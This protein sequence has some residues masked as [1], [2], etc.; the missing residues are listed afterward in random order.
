[1]VTRRG[2]RSGPWVA[3]GIGL[4]APAGA[5][6]QEAWLGAF[7]HDVPVGVALCCFEHG[8]DIQAGLRSGPLVSVPKWG[9]LRLYAL[10]SANTSGGVPFAAAGAA[11]R[12]PLGDTSLYLQPGLGAAVQFGSDAK[13]QVRPDRL[14]LGSRVLFEPELSLG[15]RADRRW[16]LEAS[17]LHLSHGQ[18]A[19]RQNPGLDDVGV[20][21]VYTFGP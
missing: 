1:L 18:L 15:W 13:Y 12:F 9:D 16:T 6:A 3:A 17:Y 7:A 20:R 5:G 10:G 14:Y 4:L 21:A 19:G 11:W 2:C 8:A